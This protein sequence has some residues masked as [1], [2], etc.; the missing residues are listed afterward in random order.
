MAQYKQWSFEGKLA[1]IAKATATVLRVEDN[2]P[3]SLTP[4]PLSQGYGQETVSFNPDASQI[5][6]GKT[7]RVTISGLSAGNVTYDVKPVT[8][9]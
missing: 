3:V 7:Y 5:Q 6:A 8:C 2:T 4:M 1:G 9:N